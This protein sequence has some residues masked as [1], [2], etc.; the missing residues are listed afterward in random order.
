MRKWRGEM[1]EGFPPRPCLLTPPTVKGEGSQVP[2]VMKKEP[3]HK[4]MQRGPQAAGERVSGGG[5]WESR[6]PVLHGEGLG[7][8]LLPPP[9]PPQLC[10]SQQALHS[11]LQPSHTLA[12][13]AFKASHTAA[14]P[15]ASGPGLWFLCYWDFC[16]RLIGFTNW[17]AEQ[18]ALFTQQSLNM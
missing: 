12:R 4:Q 8:H 15:A 18:P 9:P 11:G 6:D 7:P 1:A 13:P 17:R 14:E 2:W 3:N 16:R 10:L 5:V